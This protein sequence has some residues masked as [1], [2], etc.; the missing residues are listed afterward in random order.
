MI[1]MPDRARHWTWPTQTFPVLFPCSSSNSI[2]SVSWCLGSLKHKLRCFLPSSPSQSNFIPPS[3]MKSQSICTEM[4]QLFLH[5][6]YSLWSNSQCKL[7]LKPSIKQTSAAL[8]K[9]F[10]ERK[11]WVSDVTLFP[12]LLFNCLFLQRSEMFSL[13][14]LLLPIPETRMIVRFGSIYPFE[15]QHSPKGF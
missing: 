8:W 7:C 9:G 14:A 6:S 2:I 4:H 11:G 13:T 12:Q 5:A 3:S 15:I 10:P 1:W